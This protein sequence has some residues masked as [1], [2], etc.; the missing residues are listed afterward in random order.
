MKLSHTI[1]QMHLRKYVILILFSLFL[2][3][4]GHSFSQRF[5]GA[6]SAGVN[7]SQVDGDEVYGFKKVGINIGPSVIMPFG[8]NKKWSVTM[9]LLFSQLGSRQKSE[10]P[11]ADTVNSFQGFYDG[12]KLNLNYIQVPLIVHFTDKRVIAGGLGFLYGQLVGV[13]EYEDH[14]DPRG[15]IRID[16]TTLQGPYTLADFQVLADVRVRLYRKL[17]L[18]ARYSYSIFAIR[19][20]EYTNPFYGDKWTRNQYNNVITLRLVYI[21]NDILPDKNK[22][23]K[24]YTD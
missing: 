6:V 15:F 14:N 21:F 8:K 18:N 20:R 9:E 19:T 7:L 17:W 13:S 10:Y 12:Y 24:E 22:K 1:V 4:P 11:A 2:F 5:L 16:S 3:T 23:K